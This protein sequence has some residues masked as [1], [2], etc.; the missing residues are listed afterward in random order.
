MC[1]IIDTPLQ[2]Q[3]ILQPVF[4][5]YNIRKAILFGS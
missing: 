2:I 5:G 3:T 4:A 1:E